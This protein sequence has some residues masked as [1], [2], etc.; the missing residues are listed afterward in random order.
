MFCKEAFLLDLKGIAKA[1]KLLA[2]NRLG[3]ETGPDEFELKRKDGTT[4]TVIIRTKPIE[5]DNRKL[6]IGMVEDITER[7][8]MEIELKKRN[9]E[10]E[11]I[12]RLTIGRE[13]KMVQLKKEID[14]LKK[15]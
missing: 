12:H 2:M 5:I 4:S 14:K 15:E 6:I 1:V 7:K 11:K 8:K 9:E 10:L 13:N 3:K